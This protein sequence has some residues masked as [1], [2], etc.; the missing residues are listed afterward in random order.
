MLKLLFSIKSFYVE[1]RLKMRTI[2][3]F[4]YFWIVLILFS[5]FEMWAFH[6]KKTSTREKKEAFVF[7]CVNIWARSL[8]KL[9]GVKV[10]VEGRENIPK[11]EACVFVANHQGNFDIPIM[12]TCL[13]HP[14]GIVAKKEIDGLPFVKGWMRLLDCVFIDRENPRKAMKTINDAIDLVKGGRSMVIFPEGTRSKGGPVKEFKGGA[15]RVCEK[16]GAPIVPVCIN[17]T[18]KIMEM[19]HNRIKPA[20]VSIKILPAIETKDMDRMEL[21]ALAD[22]VREEIVGNL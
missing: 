11:D 22:A 19:N 10:N 6:L 14:N 8:L 21:K 17:G 5:P 7:P 3:W 2:I 12:L 20:E 13:D 1:R 15:F 4:I 18:Y 16:S 9:A